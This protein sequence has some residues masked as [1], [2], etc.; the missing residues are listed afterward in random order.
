MALVLMN[1]CAGGGRAA[2]LEPA[3]R[4]LLAAR[5]EVALFT[6]DTPHQAGA[7]VRAQPPG[8]R[9][10]LVG[11]DGTVHRLLPALQ[12]RGCCLGLVPAGSGDDIARALGVHGRSLEASLQQ[13]LHGP[14]QT[15]DLGQVTTPHEQRFFLSSLCMGFDAATAA[16]AH[17][18]P[19]ALTGRHRYTLATLL[20]LL[21][22]RLHGLKLELDDGTVLQGPALLSSVLNTSTYG[23]GLPA[24]PAARPDDGLLDLLHAGRF[25]RLGALRMLP[26][27]MAGRHGDH[28]QVQL[29]RLRSLA[30]QAQSP[31]PLAADGEALQPAQQLRV[32][33]LPGALQVAVGH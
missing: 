2:A 10:V 15:W 14:A 9:V 28:P 7:L 1:R 25:S 29:L 32:Q 33:V 16:R 11:G 24:A 8:S 17:A 21:R 31:L 13:A 20:E 23:G 3:L 30:L 19:E 27:L 26:T 6:P 4:H 22:L 18:L 5:P 12:E